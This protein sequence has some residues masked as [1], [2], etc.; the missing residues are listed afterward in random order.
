M[1]TG[2][3]WGEFAWGNGWTWDAEEVSRARLSDDIV[4]L[5]SARIG[6]LSDRTQ[7]A[8]EI[9]ACIGSSFT[10]ALLAT[11]SSE[12]PVLVAK[13]LW[14]ALQRG[15]LRVVGDAYKYIDRLDPSASGNESPPEIR[16]YFVHDKIQHAAYIRLDPSRRRL[17]HLRIG[18]LLRDQTHPNELGEL[19][20]RI[21]THLNASIALV[22]DRGE[23]VRLAEL[24]LLAGRRAKRSIAYNSA[25]THLRTGIELLPEEQWESC[26]ELAFSL[27]RELMESLH[28]AGDIEN[29]LELFRPLVQR[30]K[31]VL[32]K[33][34]VYTLKAAL[35]SYRKQNEL[36]VATALEGLKLLGV[37]LP[38]KATRGAAVVELAR[39]RFAQR[40]RGPAQ[41]TNLGDLDNPRKHLIL[42]LM[43][44]VVP[45]AYFIDTKL[46]AIYMLRIAGI[47]MR[48][49][50]TDAAA[51]GFAGY[52]LVLVGVLGAYHEAYEFGKLA[53]AL[54]ERFRNQWLDVKLDF[55]VGFFI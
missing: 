38:T 32:Q 25:V 3:F 42:H 5:L 22:T 49:G 50:L 27:R 34:E 53:L 40:F 44:S 33:A 4:D 8:L 23:R 10:L 14:E 16:Y 46:G 35:E 13:D 45:A 11:V 15:L 47:S 55:V 26:Y 21:T 54:N 2:Y 29:A 20:F 6:D 17:T 19:V 9:G 1:L 52:G 41:L 39:V 36:A 7:T 43:M 31:S 48:E 51:F 30:A 28:L 12:D 24:N 37:G 18:R